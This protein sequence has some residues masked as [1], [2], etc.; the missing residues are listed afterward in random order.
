MLSRFFLNNSNRKMLA[1]HAVDI[2]VTISSL[3]ASLCFTFCRTIRRH[4]SLRQVKLC[5][6]QRKYKQKLDRPT[7]RPTDRPSEWIRAHSLN[8]YFAF[9]KIVVKRRPV[10]LNT[11]RTSYFG[12]IKYPLERLF[13]IWWLIDAFLSPTQSLPL[14]ILTSTLALSQVR[15]TSERIYRKQRQYDATR[16]L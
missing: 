13:I 14:G 15:A 8:S 2:A 10:F 4:F 1:P 3:I 12:P 7:H 6:G 16:V 9:C 11:D 5:I